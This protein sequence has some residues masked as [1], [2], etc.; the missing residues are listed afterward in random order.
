MDRSKHF[1]DVSSPHGPER[2][3][4]LEHVD[5]AKGFMVTAK[6]NNGRQVAL[7]WPPVPQKQEV[8]PGV[9]INNDEEFL[10]LVK[11]ADG[12]EAEYLP[13]DRETNEIGD[14]SF[15]APADPKNDNLPPFIPKV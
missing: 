11:N 3:P 15:H 9:S 7:P 5:P 12:T 8:S 1:V 14:H 2:V 4:Y 10:V 13:Y 6:G